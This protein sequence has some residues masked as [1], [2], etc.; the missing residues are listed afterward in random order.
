MK[1]PTS[2]LIFNFLAATIA[3]LISSSVSSSWMGYLLSSNLS[4]IKNNKRS[5]E[6]FG[7]LLCPRNSDICV[8][9]CPCF[10]ENT[11]DLLTALREINKLP[12]RGTYVSQMGSF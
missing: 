5:P 8:L 6:V 4:Q 11:C 3:H 7:S 12:W 9:R 2:C 10:L 1:E